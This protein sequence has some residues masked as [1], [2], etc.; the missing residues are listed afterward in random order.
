[1]PIVTNWLADVGEQ[2]SDYAL[3][4]FPW[5]SVNEAYRSLKRH[6]DY[7]SSSSSRVLCYQV[8]DCH[9]HYDYGTP[10]DADSL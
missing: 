7:N 5:N 4:L 1:M 10:A 6:C 8:T 9:L 2:A 3:D